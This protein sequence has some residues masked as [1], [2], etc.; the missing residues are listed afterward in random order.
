MK[1]TGGCHCGLTSCEAE[2]DPATVTVPIYSAA[3]QPNPATYGSRA[4]SIDQ[5]FASQKRQSG[6][7]RRY[8]GRWICRRSI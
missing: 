8:P 7:V 4:A 3:S 6:V 5:Q 2:V 1:V